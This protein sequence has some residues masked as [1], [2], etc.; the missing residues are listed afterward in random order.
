MLSMSELVE[1]N[2]V[3]IVLDNEALYDLCK[4]KLSIE[5]P[6]YSNMNSLIRQAVSSITSALKGYSGLWGSLVELY[7]N[8]VLYKGMQFL[9]PGLMPITTNVEEDPSTATLITDRVTH[10]SSVMA[11]CNPRDGIFLTAGFMYRGNVRPSDVNPA[12]GTL[13]TKSYYNIVEFAFGKTQCGLC[14]LPMRTTASDIIVQ[15][16]RAVCMLAQTS[17]IWHVFDRMN[18]QFDKMFVNRAQVHLYEREGFELEDFK[19]ARESLEGF[20]L[21][22]REME[23][24]VGE[25][26]D[27]G[28]M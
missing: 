11:K 13:K 10:E 5:S 23:I 20:S 12:I 7:E 17:S 9:V 21:N 15:V 27:E 3:N 8:Y 14:Q 22:Y 16:P 2:D 1:H 24:E 25:D 4:E 26:S 18:E 6:T 19:S 28:M